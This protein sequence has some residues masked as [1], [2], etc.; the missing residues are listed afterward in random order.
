MPH[1]G[2]APAKSDVSG[3][4]RGFRLRLSA[5]LTLGF[6]VLLV[7][8]LF[9]SLWVSLSTGQKNTF[10]LLRAQATITVEVVIG[11]VEEYLD[12]AQEQA[13]FLAR[14][15]ADGDVDPWDDA[16]LSDIMLGSLAAGEQ[17]SGIVFVRPDFSVL[18]VGRQSGDFVFLPG[19]WKE[20]G[21][22]H[23]A[24]TD[25]AALT[26]RNWRTITLPEPFGTPH[27][28]LA[29]PVVRDEA[30]LGLVFSIVSISSLSRFLDEADRANGTHSF[31]L[32][33]RDRV[34]AH[35]SLAGG[36][37]GVSKEKP[38]PALTEV[39][40][41]IL[42]S[43]WQPSVDDMPEL[44]AGSGI[45]GHVVRGRDEH[46]IY[47]FQTLDRFG[48]PPW[49]IGTYFRE[50]ELSDYLGDLVLS[51]VVGLAILV[52]GS[53]GCL[54]LARA[55]ARPIARVEEAAGSIRRLDVGEASPLPGS[56][57]RELDNVAQAWNAMLAGLRWFET[58]VPRTLVLRLMQMGEDGL[59]SEQRQV[60]VLFTDIAGFTGLSA[61][62]T[63]VELARFL[64]EHFTALGAEIEAEE[65]TID[66]YIGD[67]VM[68][69]WGAPADQPEHALRAC[70]A[71]LAIAGRLAVVNR[72]RPAG[73]PPVRVRIG[74]HSGP[75]IV[76]NIG[77]PGRVNYTLI[78]DTVN[79]AQRLEGLAKEVP[80]EEL[81]ADAAVTILISADTA[82]ELAGRFPLASLGLRTLRG[83]DEPLEV[84]RLLEADPDA[85]TAGKI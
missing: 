77:A 23:D 1:E 41:V 24:M 71:A 25:Y 10:D 60:T 33:G 29:E 19:D 5:T 16:R 18:R 27:V 2:K 45:E 83:R 65:G 11:L 63:P 4:S 55:I 8:A 14:A 3:S 21:E 38:L 70:R 44:L 20:R 66:K 84:F 54:F 13:E 78:G 68:A 35:P 28:V 36:F 53:L 49:I 7:A 46:Y 39:N 48:E 79:V 73:A 69:F 47:L 82:A 61:Q 9:G 81:P 76:G 31:I 85:G 26:G 30:L 57:F 37:R 42:S 50:S 75:A 74:I 40:D 59:R 72:A 12:D 34:L 51:G 80:R 6:L 64:N 17:I 67:S 32:Y 15:I 43:I 52:V 56:V 58:Y 62:Q 22:I